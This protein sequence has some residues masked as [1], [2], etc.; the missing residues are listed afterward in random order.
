MPAIRAETVLAALQDLVA[1]KADD[2]L[3]QDGHVTLAITADPEDDKT[4]KNLVQ[5][6]E[7]KILS[8]QGVTGAK[9]ILTAERKAPPAGIT[10]KAA[11]ARDMNRPLHAISQRPVAPG[12]KHIVVVASGKGGVGKSTV[13]N[14]LALAFASM[15]KKTGL[16][17]ADIYGASQPRMVGRRMRPQASEDGML[18]P[19]E[20]HGIKVMSMGFFMKEEDPVIWRGPMVHSAIQQLFR[21]VA[22]NDLDI[23]VVDLPP[24]TGDAQLSLAQHIPLSG[25]VIVSTP[26]DVALSEARKGL[27]MFQKTGV[28]VLGIVENMSYHEC[29]ACGHRDDIFAHGGARMAAEKLNVPFLGEIPLHADIRAAADAGLPIAGQTHALAETY[30]NIA[31]RVWVSLPAEKTAPAAAKK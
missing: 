22:W 8:I 7:K 15:G 13:A 12:I 25:A 18:L 6:A 23:L 24:G 2:V 27:T 29:S 1:I 11:H 16:L 30:R 26:Q 19:I 5:Q 28:P 17:D 9:I 21:D 31:A 10:T 14:N 3:I 4:A 20:V